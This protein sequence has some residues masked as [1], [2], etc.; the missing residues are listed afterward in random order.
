MGGERRKEGKKEKKMPGIGNMPSLRKSKSRWAL[1]VFLYW[2]LG[3]L[4]TGYWI[5]MV[6]VHVH[7]HSSSLVV[8]GPALSFLFGVV[9]DGHNLVHSQQPTVT[10]YNVLYNVVS[11]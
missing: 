10:M 2:R 5:C 7:S 8:G 11:K 6:H 1:G 4:G 3:C 9:W